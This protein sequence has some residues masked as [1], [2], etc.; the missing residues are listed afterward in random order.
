MDTEV[1]RVSTLSVGDDLIVILKKFYDVGTTEYIN[2][3]EIDS[4]NFMLIKDNKFF[5]NITSY[6]DFMIG[7]VLDADNFIPSGTSLRILPIGHRSN[8]QGCSGK[9]KKKNR[10]K[11]LKQ[12]DFRICR[13]D[14]RTNTNLASP[15]KL[16]AKISNIDLDKKYIDL[17][18]G[19]F[20]KLVNT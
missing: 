13:K 3:I 9:I 11:K 15:I 17:S 8:R 10:Y 2:L 18:I 16:L 1:D 12:P 4:S 20:Y 5:L 14:R 7:I 19:K 6:K